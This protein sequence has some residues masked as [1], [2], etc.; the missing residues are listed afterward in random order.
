MAFPQ[1]SSR[2]VLTTIFVVAAAVGVVFGLLVSSQTLMN[3]GS[4]VKT[5]GVSVYWDSECTNPTTAIDWGPLSPGEARDCTVYVKNDGT[6]AEVLS[7]QTGNWT[8]PEVSGWLSMSWNCTDHVV[9]HETVVAAVLTLTVAPD[10]S[11]TP[12]FEFDLTIIG[13]EVT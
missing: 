11:Y 9:P 7:M 10:A 3:N 12:S 2:I 4:I 13:T 1:P 8:P 5:I 6:A